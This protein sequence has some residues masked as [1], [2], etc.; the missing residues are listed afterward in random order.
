MTEEPI[1]CMTIKLFYFVKSWLHGFI[2]Q[3]LIPQIVSFLNQP[4]PTFS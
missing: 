3:T 1:I 4:Q 2:G